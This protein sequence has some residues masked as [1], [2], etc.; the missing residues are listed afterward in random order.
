MVR[1]VEIGPAVWSQ[2]YEVADD[3]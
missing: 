2:M 1:W 3:W